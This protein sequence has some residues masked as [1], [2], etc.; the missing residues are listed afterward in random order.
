ML[1]TQWHF[2]G[3]V[4]L[5]GVFFRFYGLEQKLYWLDEVDFSMRIAGYSLAELK[6]IL[7]GQSLM[8]AETLNSYQFPQDDRT[9]AD[10]LHSLFLESTD[11]APLFYIMAK[12]WAQFL[13]PSIAVVRSASAIVSL[14]SFVGIY[15]LTQ[16]LF[17]SKTISRIS[18]LLMAVS[19]I[20]VIYA[21]EARPYS[22]LIVSTLFSTAL[23]LRALKS[24]APS[25][26]IAYTVSLI[27]GVYAHLIFVLVGISQFFYMILI[28]RSQERYA[29]LSYLK[30]ICVCLLAFSPWL[31]MLIRQPSKQTIGFILDLQ[32]NPLHRLVRITGILSRG[33]LD[34]GTGQILSWRI[35][36]LSTILVGFIMLLLAY[37][38]YVLIKTTAPST[39]QLPVALIF[40]PSIFLIVPDVL[41]GTQSGTTRYLIPVTLGLQLALSYLLGTHLA[42]ASRS[43]RSVWQFMTVIV[44][45]CGVFS[46]TLRTQTDLWWNQLPHMLGDMPASAAYINQSQQPLVIVDADMNINVIFTHVLSHQL[47]ADRQ[48]TFLVPPY[49]VTDQDQFSDIFLFK[50]SE[51]LISQTQKAYGKESEQLTSLLWKVAPD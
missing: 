27:F 28:A 47:E 32:W 39:W 33:V 25:W 41:L 31:V 15:W 24:Q 35:I 6:R 34:F 46:C 5:V 40:I 37:A 11:Q 4:I 44:V 49:P 17:Q 38:V 16:E 42:T 45:S 48:L 8:S 3:A 30:A 13:G 7:L 23:L 22:L 50:P 51:A 20:H 43:G 2:V 10:L 12:Y 18:L 26:W 36:V 14:F 21:Q 1:L 29:F 19:P 9:L